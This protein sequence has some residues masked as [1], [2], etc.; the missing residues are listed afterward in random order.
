MLD[1]RRRHPRPQHLLLPH[2]QLPQQQAEE[3]AIHRAVPKAREPAHTGGE[4]GKLR[5]RPHFVLQTG[6]VKT[7][8]QDAWD[9]LLRSYVYVQLQNVLRKR[10]TQ[11][12]S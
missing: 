11:Q 9:A 7:V 4:A 2:R 10:K 12:R 1:E 5:G 8:C 3:A 6:G